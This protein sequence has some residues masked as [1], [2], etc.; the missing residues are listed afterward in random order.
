MELE[1]RTVLQLTGVV[2]VGG[3]VAACGSSTS[4]DASSTPAA[5]GSAAAGGG[6]TKAADVPVGGGVVLADPAVVVTQPTAGDFKAFSSICTH[7]GC[8]VSEVTDNQIVCPCHG[9]VFSA[10]DG[11]VLKGPAT[12]PLPAAK[13]SV[14]GDTLVVST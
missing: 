1:R 3:L 6:A 11:A 5:G 8:A 2:A 9:S 10:T 13:V 12:Q 4:S 7:Q 14:E